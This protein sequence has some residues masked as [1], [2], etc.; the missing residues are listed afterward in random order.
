MSK[1]ATKYANASGLP[2][3]DAKHDLVVSVTKT[4]VKRGDNKN[5]ENCALARAILA[6]RPE[7]KRVFIFRT[8]A[9]VETAR[10]IVR[11][12]LPESVQREVEAFDRFGVFEPGA[13]KIKAPAPT[14]TKAATKAYDAKR[15][16]K[17]P[18]NKPP[19]KMRHAD[20]VRC[21]I[22]DPT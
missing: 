8:T 7:A 12:A 10:R 1:F 20:K 6:E 11:Y 22:K 18:T 3:E 13:Y 14:R 2:V 15:P 21:G 5:P 9:I 17:K 16:K 19:R 4:D